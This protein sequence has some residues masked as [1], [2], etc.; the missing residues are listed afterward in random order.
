MCT[1]KGSDFAKELFMLIQYYMKMYLDVV[2]GNRAK[3]SG[4]NLIHTIGF[5]KYNELINYS[6]LAKELVHK[7]I[8][9][10]KSCFDN[11]HQCFNYPFE[12]K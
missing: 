2:P 4:Q 8:T 10:P 6:C 5:D 11:E 12:E 9:L 1:P 3:T 7:L